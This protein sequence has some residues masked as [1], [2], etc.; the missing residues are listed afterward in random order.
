MLDTEPRQVILAN[1]ACSI[2]R[3]NRGL[4]QWTVEEFATSGYQS[5]CFRTRAELLAFLVAVPQPL[6]AEAIASQVDAGH[7]TEPPMQSCQYCGALGDDVC[8]NS[9]CPHTLCDYCAQT[10]TGC[11]ECARTKNL[12]FDLDATPSEAVPPPCIG[13][14]RRMV[15]ACPQCQGNLFELGQDR[16]YRCLCCHARQTFPAS[17]T[18]APANGTDGPTNGHGEGE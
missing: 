1:R 16:T 14:L 7:P 2:L 8:A 3:L 17:P 4:D 12:F 6:L 18:L 5:T 11:P 13:D 9:G 15:L 10:P